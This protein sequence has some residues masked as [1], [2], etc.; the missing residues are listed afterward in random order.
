MPKITYKP[1]PGEPNEITWGN[2]KFKAGEGVD[3]DNPV[4][5]QKA[6]T[7]PYFEVS[8]ADKKG[9]G[10]RQQGD[11]I[12]GYRDAFTGQD[13]D[14]VRR[15]SL[16]GYGHGSSAPAEI[17]KPSAAT[18]GSVAVEASRP[19]T[20]PASAD[21]PRFRETFGVSAA[22]LATG[23]YE[24]APEYKGPEGTVGKGETPYAKE[25]K[26]QAQKQPKGGK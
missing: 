6:Q 11:V 4:M 10:Q 21:N 26:A 20:G 23:E 13:V 16:Y 24:G 19:V 8:G 5:L 12:G 14:L 7:N 9:E 3:V 18:Q 25:Q 22:E 2:Q 15:Q 17:G 1:G